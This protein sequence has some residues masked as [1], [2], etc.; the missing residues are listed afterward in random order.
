MGLSVSCVNCHRTVKVKSKLAGK[1]VRCPRCGSPVSVPAVA[2]ATEPSLDRPSQ[3]RATPTPASP[4]R[5]SSH[6]MA[7]R[8]SSKSDAAQRV[9]SRPDAGQ[10]VAGKRDSGKFAATR[11]DSGK[12][13]TAKPDTAQKLD[14]ND[15][16]YRPRLQKRRGPNAIA[17]A[18]A[19]AWESL[20]DGRREYA[21]GLAI[22]VAI[23]ALQLVYGGWFSS[24]KPA[25]PPVGA[26]EE[27]TDNEPPPAKKGPVPVVI[28]DSEKKKDEADKKGDKD[29]DVKATLKRTKPV[30]GKDNAAK[31]NA[32]KDNAAQKNAG[33]MVRGSR[34]AL[35]TF[36]ARQDPQRTLLAPTGGGPTQQ[37]VPTVKTDHTGAYNAA[38][39]PEVGEVVVVR[40]RDGLHVAK[41]SSVDVS[42]LQCEI[43]VLDAGAYHKRGQIKETSRTDTVRFGQ[44]R[45]PT[46]LRSNRNM[47]PDFGPPAM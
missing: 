27:A 9:S 20:G 12:F 39:P 15:E 44:M 5:R 10:R 37:T 8:S 41:V 46:F 11:G 24:T 33:R 47:P 18:L 6:E 16:P 26:A 30:A 22:I 31:D 45:P 42:E 7:Q 32:A 38:A 28:V 3:G 21:V 23:V 1:T 40:L 25:H 17:T 19:G 13:D 29:A 34:P 43:I 36:G 14:D 4:S 35:S 2:Q